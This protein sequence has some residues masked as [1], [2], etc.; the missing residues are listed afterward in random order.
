MNRRRAQRTAGVAGGRLDPDVLERAFAQD[1]AVGDAVQGHAAGQHEICASPFADARAGAMRS[2]ISSVTAWIEAARSISRC[3]SFRFGLPRRSAE[4]AMKL[5]AGHRQALAV[6]EVA[7][8]HA[9]RAVV[10]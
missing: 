1:A 7:H 5:R 2:M 6:V 9:E 8:V 4:Q 10:V 3:V